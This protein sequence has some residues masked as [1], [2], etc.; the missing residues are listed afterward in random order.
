MWLCVCDGACVSVSYEEQ[1]K[2]QRLLCLLPVCAAD[3]GHSSGPL[4]S[5]SPGLAIRDQWDIC[6]PSQACNTRP[7]YV[8][9]YSNIM[10]AH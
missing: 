2:D 8:L 3:F 1:L 10:S 6:W 5:E 4:P 9:V 7:K